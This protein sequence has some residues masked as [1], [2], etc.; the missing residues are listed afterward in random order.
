[1]LRIAVGAVLVLAVAVGAGGAA[2]KA[3]KQ[4]TKQNQ[5]VKGTVKSVDYKNGVLVVSQK[6][7]GET[8]DR[9]LDIKEETAFEITV[10]GEKKQ[11]LFG[12]EGLALL[13]EGAQVTVKCDKDVNVLKV[14]AKVK[15]KK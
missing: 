3:D 6:L 12:K 11:D 7:K 14:T 13:E 9:Q 4:K 15:K 10:E 2:D 5:M 8:V 1:M